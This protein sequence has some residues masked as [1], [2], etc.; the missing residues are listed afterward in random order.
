[1]DRFIRF[2]PNVTP[3]DRPGHYAYVRDYGT[4]NELAGRSF[5][6][7]GG[8]RT[9]SW[10]PVGKNRTR[11]DIPAGTAYRTSWAQETLRREKRH[12]AVPAPLTAS[13]MGM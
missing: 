7:A 5:R 1:M 3:M 13:V 10:Q 6:S 11:P 9:P 12:G 4:P 2:R 8:C